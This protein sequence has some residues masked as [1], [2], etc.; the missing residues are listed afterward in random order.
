[1]D[2]IGYIWLKMCRFVTLIKYV[3]EMLDDRDKIRVFS[4]YHCVYHSVFQCHFLGVPVVKT[5][6]CLINNQ[7][8]QPFLCFRILM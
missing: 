4:V 1:M 8:L 7:V 2:K 6:N 3:Y 5:W